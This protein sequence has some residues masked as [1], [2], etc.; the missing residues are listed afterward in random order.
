[1]NLL[2]FKNNYLSQTF[3]I[4]S[5]EQ[6]QVSLLGDFNINL[7]NYNAHQPT[8]EFLN[9]LDSNSLTP[10]FLLPTRIPSH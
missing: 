3:E 5:K 10:Y 7:V 6:K 1:M 4:I 9:L 2:D 8:N